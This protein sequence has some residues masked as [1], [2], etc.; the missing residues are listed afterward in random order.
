MPRARRLFTILLVGSF[1]ATSGILASEVLTSALTAEAADLNQFD[2]GNIMSDAKFYDGNALSESEV[3]TFL[4]GKVPTCTIN[5]GQPSHA[6]GA[7]Y[8]NSSGAQYSTVAS[9]CLKDY[10]QTT[11]NMTGE[12]GKCAAFT[13]NSS[14][15]AASIIARIGQACNVSQKVLLVLL[16]K[17]Q[18]LVRDT[19]PLVK[20][21]DSA[22][23][24]A[25]YDNGQPCVGGYAG[26]FYQVW[27]AALQFQRYGTGSFTWYPVGQVSNI[28]YQANNADCGTRA[29]FISNRATAALYYYTPYTPNAAALAAGYGLGDACS[30][31]GN[32]N[33]YQLYVDWFG[34]TQGNP[35]PK[36]MSSTPAPTL[37]RTGAVLPG[38]VL[39]AV[40]SGWDANVAF[41]YQW[42]RNGAAI[43][44]GNGASYTTVLA[45]NGTSIQVTVTG[46]K[47]GYIASTQ[48]SAASAQ[49]TAPTPTAA[50][51]STTIQSLVSSRLADTRPGA[52]TID[53][54]VSG[55]GPIGPGKILR[56]PILG[57]NGI[58]A[59][60]VDSVSLNV[61]VVAGSEGGFITVFPTGTALPNASNVNFLAGKIVPN[62]VQVK[63]GSDGSISVFSQANNANIIVDINGWY[64]TGGSF[65]TFTPARLL[66]TRAGSQTV[67]G[68]YRAT[69]LI[70]S[71]QTIRFAALGRNGVPMSGVT[72]VSLNVT[73]VMPSTE[74]FLTVFPSGTA[75]PNA[76]NLNFYGGQT[77]A[78]T[79]ISKVGA[80]GTISVYNG[81]GNTDLVVDI[82]GWYSSAPGFSSLSPARLVDTRA[83]SSTIDGQ[84]VR[85]GAIGAGQT[86]RLKVLDRAGVPSTGVGAVSLNVTAVTPSTVGQLIIYPSGAAMPNTSN[87]NFTSTQTVANAVIAKVGADGYINIV[88]NSSGSTNL[89]VDVNGW[90]PASN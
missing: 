67:D 6:A 4:N 17:E 58:P 22:T 5:N 78:N 87:L 18:S 57:R 31:Y 65:T 89:V 66:D 11:P 38:E 54:Q 71:G 60:G 70:R 64:P 9:T 36:A 77:R 44:G 53:G 1:I 81:G 63:V 20:Q 27:A 7:P 82:S 85:I 40:I 74:G 43:S 42:T 72:A 32:R 83:G 68:Q 24:F 39:T 37:S 26:F 51:S 84:F 3:Q 21:Y 49:V 88:N 33:F 62:A 59:T 16:E 30:A 48:T 55:T 90:F 10:S 69:G 13:G 29:T 41:T 80:D 61:T 2:A 12:A 23:G 34:S 45:D 76:S 46:T 15:S 86:L 75:L 79:V 28:L 50:T 19:W 56:V 73:S 52:Q 25:C 47:A 35:D 14:E 8:Y